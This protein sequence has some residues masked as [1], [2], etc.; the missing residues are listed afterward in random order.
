MKLSKDKNST[1]EVSDIN[2]CYGYV[3]YRYGIAGQIAVILKEFV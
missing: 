2:P 3:S 1:K